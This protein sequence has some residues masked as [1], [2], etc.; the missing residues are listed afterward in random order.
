MRTDHRPEPRP[1]SEDQA[2]IQ[3]DRDHDQQRHIGAQ[4][5][6]AQNKGVLS[7][8]GDDQPAHQPETGQG[9]GK[10]MFMASL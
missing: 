2:G 10:N 3:S 7:A 5:S 9:R 1:S 4:Q 6:L 8:D